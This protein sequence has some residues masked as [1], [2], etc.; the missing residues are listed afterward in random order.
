[1]LNLLSAGCASGEEAYSLAIV[2][3]E[4]HRRP[5]LGSPHPGG[6]SE[7]GGFGEGGNPRATRPGRS[8]NAAGCPAQ[9]VSPGRPR[10]GPSSRPRVRRAIRA[11][12]TWPPRIPNFGSRA[13]YDV[14][15]CRNV[16]M[17]FSPEQMRALG[18]AYRPIP[19]AGRLPVPRP[20]RD[21]ARRLG[22]VSPAAHPRHLL[23]PAQGRRRTHLHRRRCR[24]ALAASRRHTPLSPPR[25]TPGST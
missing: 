19:G 20:R 8:G 23:L 16:M 4:C 13:L 11:S 12:A 15:F 18:R 7:S 1:M 21:V 24:P 9:M 22:R 10:H 2:A 6:R 14:V 5:V 3:R 17:Y 25:P